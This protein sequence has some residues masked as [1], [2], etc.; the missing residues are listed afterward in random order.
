M[1]GNKNFFT[2]L[3][4]KIA[5]QVKLGDGKLYEVKGK[6]VVF[7]QTKEGKSKLIHEVLYVP[8]LT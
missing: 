7:V 3:D 4:E 2:S 1:T 6:G 5:S 8:G